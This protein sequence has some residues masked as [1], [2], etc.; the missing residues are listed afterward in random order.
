M[1]TVQPFGK[2]THFSKT[3][4]PSPLIQPHGLIE[5][6]LT[7]IDS[8]GMIETTWDQDAEINMMPENFIKQELSRAYVRAVTSRAGHDLSITEV[9]YR[10]IDGTIENPSLSGVN[11][12]DFQLKS[13]TDYELRGTNIIYDLRVEDYNR[14][15]RD[16]EIP[17]VLILF[18]MPDDD[19]E[20]LAQS[21]DELCLRR[22]AYWVSLMGKEPSSNRSTV[23]VSLPQ[24]NVFDRSGLRDMFTRLGLV[25]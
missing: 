1:Q 6:R 11:R 19:A 2:V 17:R 14:L 16:L 21:V 4:A 15:I 23:R 9:D 22:C 3:G 7:L 8:G 5:C 10:G 20:W 18:T 25:T 12:V 13:T 24:A